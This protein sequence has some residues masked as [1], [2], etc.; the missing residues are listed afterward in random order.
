MNSWHRRL[1]ILFQQHSRQLTAMATRR[2]RDKEIAGE[3]VQDVYTRLL[4]SGGADNHDDDAK[5]LYVSVRNAVI[6]HRRRNAHRQRAIE[7]VLP[8]QIGLPESSSPEDHV[9]AR[10]ALSALDQA[11]LALRP[12][13]REI[14]ILHRV[15]GVPNAQIAKRYGI[16]VSAV[17]K[18]LARAMRHCQ[19]SLA[20]HTDET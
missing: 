19:R 20:A 14:F 2:V 17:E 16:S 18:Q 1:A 10:Q 7:Q 4:Q 11:L 5:I 3:I 6:D 15:K 8:S 13:A 12:Q 9:E